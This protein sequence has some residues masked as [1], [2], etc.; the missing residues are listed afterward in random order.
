[1]GCHRTSY[2]AQEGILIFEGSV[3]TSSSVRGLFLVVKNSL[4]RKQLVC[5][6][7]LPLRL[8]ER[9]GKP[10]QSRYQ[11]TKFVRN[12]NGIPNIF[13]IR[14][15][16]QFFADQTEPVNQMVEFSESCLNHLVKQKQSCL[17][18]FRCQPKRQP[19]PQCVDAGR[20]LAIRN[21][22]LQNQEC[23][24]GDS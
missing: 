7:F 19:E 24:R 3:F 8:I 21:L 14:S 12:I 5:T 20:S 23:F 10:I 15:R 11:A 13:S 16:E 6:A 2:E 18:N 4:L 9:N 22:P 17:E 1:M